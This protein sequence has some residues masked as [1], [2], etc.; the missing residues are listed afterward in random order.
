[1]TEP[2]TMAVSVAVVVLRYDTELGESQLLLQKTDSTAETPVY[3]LPAGNL[4]L[5]QDAEMSAYNTLSLVGVE[6]EQVE[7]LAFSQAFTTVDRNTDY[8][9][10]GLLMVAQVAES[11]ELQPEPTHTTEWFSTRSEET[12]V[13]L[14][15]PDKTIIAYRDGRAIGDATLVLDHSNMITSVM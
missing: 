3:A 10:V 1:M 7:S 11:A 2:S 9:E 5:D 8:R 6:K 4:A 15:T 12:K 14:S 13:L